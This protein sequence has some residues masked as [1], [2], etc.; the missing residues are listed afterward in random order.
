MRGIGGDRTNSALGWEPLIGRA[1]VRN[2]RRTGRPRTAPEKIGPPRDTR[3]LHERR[4]GIGSRRIGGNRYDGDRA[5]DGCHSACTQIPRSV[6]H[7]F[8]QPPYGHDEPLLSRKAVLQRV[9][10]APRSLHA[11]LKYRDAL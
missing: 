10:S 9:L 2:I 5:K 4:Y 3:L 11:P 7:Q 6:L 1:V 8:A